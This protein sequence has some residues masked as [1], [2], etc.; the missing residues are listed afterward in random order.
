MRTACPSIEDAACAAGS[1]I[2]WDGEWQRIGRPHGR[3]ACFSF[4]PRK[5]I[6]TGDGGMLTTDDPELD[7]RFRL[8]RQHGMSVNDRVRHGS[9]QV[10]FEE[11]AVVGFNYRM[12]DIQAAVGREQLQRLPGIIAER[13]RRSPS[14]TH[15]LLADVPGVGAPVE[16][17]WARSNWQSYAVRLPDGCDQRTVMQ[18]M[19]DRGVSTRR[20]IMCAHRERPYAGEHHLPQSEDSQDRYILLPLYSG[21][22]DADAERVVEAL[23]SATGAGA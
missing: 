2:R 10:I 20:G 21:L 7:A 15:E 19:L 16:P 14:A 4:H 22:D 17:E 3:V 13:R 1:E 6:S 11:H 12:T 18:A 23:R 8:L 5:V 9:N